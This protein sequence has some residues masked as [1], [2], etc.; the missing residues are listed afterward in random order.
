MNRNSPVK[1]KPDGVAHPHVTGSVA[2]PPEPDFPRISI[3]DLAAVQ[4][5]L[6]AIPSSA[7]PESGIN[8]RSILHKM[9]MRGSERRLA[10]FRSPAEVEQLAE[11]FPN[12]TAALEMVLSCI[13]LASLSDG[14]ISLPP[15]LLVGGPG[16]GKTFFAGRM[17]EVLGLGQGF[18][19]VNMENATNGSALSGLTFTWGNG[20]PGRIFDKLVDGR[21]ANPL[22]VIDEVDKASTDSRWNPLAPLYSLLEPGTAARFQDEAVPMVPIDASRINW[23]L[24]A[25]DIHQIPEPLLSRMTV[26]QVPEPTPAQ[27]LV[28]AKSIYRHQRKSNSWGSLF[29]KRLSEDVARRLASMPPRQ[30]KTVLRNA[31]GLAARRKRRSIQVEDLQLPTLNHGGRPRIGFTA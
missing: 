25:N 3:Y 26:V 16:I 20:Q 24:T 22:I 13:A 2:S 8:L 10:T 17:A 23:V 12:F 18:E 5:A 6:D 21:F 9:D 11:S 28:I 14:V 27:A 19:V 1:P 4:S 15:I 31:F 30:M 29:D 7:R